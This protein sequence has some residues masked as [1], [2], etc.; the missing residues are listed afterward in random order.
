MK[1][2]LIF[3]PLFLFVLAGCAGPKVYG[4]ED[5]KIQMVVGEVVQI[6]PGDPG[7]RDGVELAWRMA[8]PPDFNIVAL[9]Q[10]H[11]DQNNEGPPWFFEG[12]GA[13]ETFVALGREGI[14]DPGVIST[15]ITYSFTVE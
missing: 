10:D 13:G 6:A 4:P 2:G 11:K 8:V 5:T 1:P 3:V 15:G 14:L 12:V 7:E 9:S